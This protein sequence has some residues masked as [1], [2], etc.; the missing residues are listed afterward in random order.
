LQAFYV[1]LLTAISGPVFHGGEWKLCERD[2]W[3]DNQ[4]CQN[5]VAWSWAKDDDRRLIAVNLSDNPVHA[6][7]HVPWEEVRG[8]TWHLT[9]AL[10]DTSYERDGDEMASSGL[11]VELEPWG[12]SF[13]QCQ[14]A[15]R[16]ISSKRIA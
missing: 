5:L 2:G 14:L 13:F 4:S 16:E 11:Y 3:P 9:D 15:A 12:Y 10:S 8:E 6:R 1:R 7:V